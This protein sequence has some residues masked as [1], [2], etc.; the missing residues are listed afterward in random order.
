MSPQL[1]GVGVQV[2][3]QHHDPE[4][5][6]ALPGA[7][8]HLDHIA[9]HETLATLL[10]DRPAKAT[11][12]PRPSSIRARVRAALNRFVVCSAVPTSD[13]SSEQPDEVSQKQDQCSQN[14]R[15]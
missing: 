10:G 7:A 2:Q 4:G 6:E 13:R 9:I 1:G 14:A 8:V 5:P 15:R 11:N 12:C 3:P